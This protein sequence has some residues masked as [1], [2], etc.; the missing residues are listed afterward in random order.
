MGSST[1]KVYTKHLEFWRQ[2]KAKNPNATK[3]QFLKQRDIIE[4]KAWGNKGDTPT[5]FLN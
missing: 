2:F 4:Q 1:M 3:E 5:K